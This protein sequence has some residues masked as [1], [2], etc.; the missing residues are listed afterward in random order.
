MLSQES[1]CYHQACSNVIL[2]YS[3]YDD[4]IDD[5]QEDLAR[6]VVSLVTNCSG[7]EVSSFW[8]LVS[9]I[10]NYELRQFYQEGLPGVVL[11]GEVLSTL[12]DNHLPLVG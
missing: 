3:R 4:S 9:L 2:A 5:T 7:D 8:I 11:Y 1:Q 10:E 12:L 6:V